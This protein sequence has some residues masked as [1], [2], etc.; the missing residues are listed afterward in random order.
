MGSESQ[1]GLFSVQSWLR[2]FMVIAVAHGEW[3]PV[4]RATMPGAI[5][6]VMGLRAEW[7]FLEEP[8]AAMGLKDH[9]L[10][11]SLW[12][13]P[14]PKRGLLGRSVVP[15]SVVLRNP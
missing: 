15:R 1:K 6:D 11:T 3:S 10:L 9:R 12:S 4:P 8:G 14:P 5:E 13:S 2:S 7:I